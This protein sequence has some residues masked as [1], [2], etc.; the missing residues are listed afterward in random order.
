M[1]NLNDGIS[2]EDKW[3]EEVDVVAAGSM[4]Q[5]DS[6]YLGDQCQHVAEY[7]LEQW[8]NLHRG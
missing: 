7:F 8:K 6:E 2:F 1:V 4:Y 3:N 5:F